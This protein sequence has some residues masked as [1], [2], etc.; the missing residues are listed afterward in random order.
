MSENNIQNDQDLREMEDQELEQTAGGTFTPNTYIK[1][2]Y[3]KIGIST[4][5]HFFDKD[6]FRFMGKS[7]TYDEANDI[8]K[9]G[10]RVMDAIN[11]G[12]DGSNVVGYN[13]NEFIRAMNSQLKLKYGILWDGKPGSDFE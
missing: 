3:H 4:N 9:M 10:K 7:I 2:A 12:Y 1:K 6:E 8:V 13:E 5:Y 11:S